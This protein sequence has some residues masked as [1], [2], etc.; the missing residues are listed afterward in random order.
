M[1]S[2]PQGSLS[3]ALWVV[4]IFACLVMIFASTIAGLI[5]MA[6]ALARWLVGRAVGLR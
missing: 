2:I 4:C 1:R 6:A 3:Q 5:V